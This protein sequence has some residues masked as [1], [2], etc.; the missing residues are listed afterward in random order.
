MAR[1]HGSYSSTEVLIKGSAD[2][3]NAETFVA[4]SMA[5]RP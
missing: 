4:R 1:H 2:L 5:P 3:K